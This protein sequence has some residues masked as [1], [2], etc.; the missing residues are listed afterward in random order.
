MFRRLAW[1]WVAM[2]MVTGGITGH[3]AQSASMDRMMAPDEFPTN[4]VKIL[5]TTNKAQTNSYV[6]VVFTMRN[7]NPFNVIRFLHPPVKAEEGELFTFVSD[8]GNSGKVLFVVPQYMVES[9]AELVKA[10]DRPGLTTSSGSERVYR[11][12]KHRRVDL[13]DPGFLETAASFST[14]NGSTFV[15]HLLVGLHL[16]IID[17]QMNAVY[18]EDAP[19][20]VDALD[21]ALTEWLD[22]PTAMVQ[23]GVKI[24]EIDAYND[25][26]IG[27]DYMAWKNGPG[28]NLFAVGAYHEYGSLG[29]DSNMVYQPLDLGADLQSLPRHSFNASGYNYA[30]EYNV[31]SAFF[32]YLAEQGKARI[33]NQMKLAALNTRMATLGAGDQIL[34]YKTTTTDPSGIRDSGQP[35]QAN[36]G[37]VVVGTTNQLIANQLVPVDT[38]LSLAFIPTIGEQTIQMAI[39]LTWSDYNGFSSDGSPQINSRNLSTKVRM[40]LG[41]EIIIGGLNRQVHVNTT[42]KMPFLGSLPIIGYAFG[43]ETSQNRKTEMI[44]AIQ[45]TAVTTYDIAMDDQKI[46]DQVG[47]TATIEEPK[48]TFGFGMWGLDKEKGAVD[49]K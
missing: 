3:A 32:D 6:P 36:D 14:G 17:P 35:F 29:R 4:V 42:A 7:N 22:V 37:R 41:D 9:L 8:D 40:G 16:Y 23:L 34:Y 5:R 47:G 25:D 33:L 1:L 26:T 31:S 39:A 24:Y 38:G 45:P 12:L 48:T 19:S 18:F 11:A 10:V 46:M 15:I 27:L 30:Y 20:G 2:M 49:E 13:T 21:T 43:G 28:A 44:V